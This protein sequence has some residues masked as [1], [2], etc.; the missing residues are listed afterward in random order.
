MNKIEQLMQC[1][2]FT[3]NNVSSLH[4]SIK[5]LN[6]ILNYLHGLLKPEH[7][8]SHIG[9]FEY[10]NLVLYYETESNISI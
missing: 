6:F 8:R 1:F 7:N 10:Y 4:Y 2:Q 5:S 9:E 3:M